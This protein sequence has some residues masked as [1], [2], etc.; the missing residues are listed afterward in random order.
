MF[1]LLYRD[2]ASLRSRLLCVDMPV[3]AM[4]EFNGFY[5][6]KWSTCRCL[7]RW[8]IVIYFIAIFT[9]YRQNV[10]PGRVCRCA[11]CACVCVLTCVCVDGGAIMFKGKCRCG[12][13]ACVCVLTCACVEGGAVMFK[14]ITSY[15]GDCVCALPC[16]WCCL[17]L[18]VRCMRVCV[19]AWVCVYVYV[20]AHVRVC[21][22]GVCACL[23]CMY[24]FARAV[25]VCVSCRLLGTCAH[26]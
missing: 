2:T 17:C 14:N 13:C 19:C 5:M 16:M 23:R 15:F 3:G 12:V 6:T 4:S 11:V 1:L 26:D 10:L 22:R 8:E 25:C 20:C 9:V 21:M 24:A 18:D 7:L